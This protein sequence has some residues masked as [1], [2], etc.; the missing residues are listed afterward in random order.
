MTTRLQ[1]II[2]DAR[3][4]LG[5]VNA[6]RWQDDRLLRLANAAQLDIA[7]QTKIIKK[8]FRINLQEGQYMYS[9]P[10]DVW[11]ILRATYNNSPIALKTYDEMDDY[12][13]SLGVN[14]L[15]RTSSGRNSTPN[16][17]SLAAHYQ[18]DNDSGPDALALIYDNRNMGEIRVYPIPKDVSDTSYTFSK[19]GPPE[20]IGDELTGVI[21]AIDDYT[22]N[23]PHGVVTGLYDPTI[24]DEFFNDAHGVVTSIGET[25]KLIQV[26]CIGRPKDLVSVFSDL[27]IASIY[28]DAI[29]HY[30]VAHAYDDDTDTRSLEKSQKAFAL[31]ER[32]LKIPAATSRRDGVNSPKA[33]QSTYRGPFNA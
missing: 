28:D 16:S 21:V 14:R 23:S 7:R 3:Y 11:L 19:V 31:Y 1:Q 33:P 27:E 8:T 5:D 18:W 10:E 25:D 24:V 26:W 22:F 12:T 32:E 20:F 13:E 9:L 15:G 2:K 6:E 29:M 17:G 30:I 4:K